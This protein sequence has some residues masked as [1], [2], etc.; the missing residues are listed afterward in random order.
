MTTEER[1][2]VYDTALQMASRHGAVLTS[3]LLKTAQ[4]AP[5]SGTAAPAPSLYDRFNNATHD[6]G[7]KHLGKGYGNY[8]ST[9]AGMATLGALYGLLFGDKKHGTLDAILN[10]ALLFGGLGIGGQY[11]RNLG[12]ADA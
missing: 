4:E 7:E 5:A 3:L 2:E 9:G 8:A 1:K 11:M 12:R 10:N 6:W